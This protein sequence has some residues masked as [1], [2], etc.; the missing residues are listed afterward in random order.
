MPEALRR[1]RVTP[2]RI[3]PPMPPTGAK[4]KATNL[5]TP[6]APRARRLPSRV[7]SRLP[8]RRRPL[9]PR[10][11]SR[12]VRSRLRTPDPSGRRRFPPPTRGILPW[13][14]NTFRPGRSLMTSRPIL[15]AARPFP[16]LRR[17]SPPLRWLTPGLRRSRRMPRP[18]WRRAHHCPA[19]SHRPNPRSPTFRPC[20]RRRVPQSRHQF[21][22]RFRRLRRRLRRGPLVWAS[23]WAGS[24]C[25]RAP[26]REREAR[27]RRLRRRPRVA[28]SSRRVEGHNARRVHRCRRGRG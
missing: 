26:A 13:R 7:T 14:P 18:R 6:P 19:P 3:L 5:P 12:W 15:R 25:P 9:S 20:R 10:S 24:S 4:P 17:S 28:G 11:P 23:W 21:R 22:L 2:R 27:R 16:P 1:V 8:C